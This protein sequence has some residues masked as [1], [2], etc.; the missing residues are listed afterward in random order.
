MSPSGPQEVDVVERGVAW[1]EAG[2]G[3]VVVFLHGLGGTRTAW[4]PQLR[5][6]SHRFRCVA[7]DMP[8]YGDSEPLTPLTFD[9]VADRLNRLFDVLEADTVDLVGFSFGGM[10]ALHTALAYPARIR[11]MVLAD[12]SPAFGLDGTKADDWI[13]QRLAPIEAGASPADAAEAVVDAITADP[14]VGRE[15]AE[16]IEAFGQISSRGFTAAVRCLPSHDVRDR[17]AEISQPCRVLVGELDRE[18]PPAYAA[19]LAEGLPHAELQV[20]DGAG[21]LT[22][23]EAPDEFNR[24]VEEFL[25]RASAPLGTGPAGGDTAAGDTAAGDTEGT[26]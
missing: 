17:L 26:S 10:H 3:P 16:T 5:G 19:A 20:I 13:R 4:G 15:R 9:G 18:T 2:S 22:P 7:W 14:L 1:R 8:G 6:L 21:H 24:L 23:A 12:T 25:T 11:R